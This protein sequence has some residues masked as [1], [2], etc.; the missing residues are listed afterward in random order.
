MLVSARW[1]NDYLSPHATAEEQA[2]LLTAAGF[3]LEGREDLEDG[4]VRQDFEMTSNRGDCVCHLGLAREIAA[5]SSRSLKAPDTAPPAGDAALPAGT[6]VTNDEPD[7]CPLYTARVILGANVT[8]SPDWLRERITARGDVPRTNVVDATNFVLFEQGQPTHVF[9]LDKL[10]G[11]RV[12]I[13]RARQGETLLPIGEGAKEIKL[14]PDDLV[15]ADA[16]NPVALAGVKGGASTAVTDD[17]TNLLIEAATFDPVIVREMSRRHNITSDSSFRFSRG[18][19]PLQVDSCAERLVS[20]LLDV[21]G[22]TR[23]NEVLRDGQ[24][25]PKLATASM[26]GDRCRQRLGVDLSDQEMCDVLEGL[27]FDTTLAGG[28]ITC[29]I[30]CHRGDIAREI[31]LIEEVGRVHGYDH[32]PVQDSLTVRVPPL[33][34]EVTGRRAVLD[35]LA[36][37]G[38][39]ECITHSLVATDAAT[40]FLR[41]GE[42]LLEIDDD[43]AAAE[44]ALRPSV[45]PSLLRVRRHNFDAGGDAGAPMRLAEI[46]TTFRLQGGTHNETVQLGLV[47]DA[48]DAVGLRHLR[49][50]VDRVIEVLTGNTAEIIAGSLPWLSAGGVI[51]VAGKQVGWI[52][53]LA[54]ALE[55]T[56]DLP[57]AVDIAEI[58]LE[59]M[60][61]AYPPPRAPSP[62]PTHPAIERDISA[63]VSN[64]TSWMAVRNAVAAMSLPHLEN[65]VFVGVYRGKGIPEG[66]KSL[67]LRLRFRAD[68]R[69]LTHDEVD[70]PT[71]DATAVLVEKLAAEIRS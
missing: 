70:G 7:L 37:M 2:D 48:E 62:L 6:S 19:S 20:I 5:R 27:G 40:P 61:A 66:H 1:I 26:R 33:Q 57:N 38:F 15:I 25:P 16:E 34:G 50:I 71:A 23:C 10:A 21:A 46:G 58:E 14:T 28:E 35:A 43:R 11:G 45:I 12:E 49:G 68:D 17:T 39:I 32:I 63:I 44:P 53:R 42:S 67:T 9:D 64:E 69:T 3:P 8:P 29:T 52:G 30:P 55:K 60:F 13:R 59:A 18:V 41:D 36:G 31:D 51:E 54:D 4:D 56:W 24:S 65:I 22:G 47:V